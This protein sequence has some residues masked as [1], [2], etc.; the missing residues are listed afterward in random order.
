MWGKEK[1]IR[2]LDM[3]PTHRLAN[4]VVVDKVHDVHEPL[5]HT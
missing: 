4:G 1:T 5:S 3:L 2:E